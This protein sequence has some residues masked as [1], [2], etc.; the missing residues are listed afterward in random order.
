MVT[1]IPTYKISPCSNWNV[2]LCCQLVRDCVLHRHWLNMELNLESFFGLHVTWCEQLY[3]LAET[4]HL[5][6][7]HI[8]QE[9]SRRC[10]LSWLA[11]SALIYESKC[12]GPSP[13]V[14]IRGLQRDVVYLCWPIAP[15]DM[16]PNG[17]GWG[18]GD[19]GVSA[20]EYSYAHHVTWSPNKL[21]I[22]TVYLHI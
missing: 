4:P 19:C 8:L 13:T 1:E 21:W 12:G 16:S 6:P 14:F 11:N 3:S 9:V 7:P 10:R 22:S 17:G 2:R 18:G 20:N 5:P 15:K